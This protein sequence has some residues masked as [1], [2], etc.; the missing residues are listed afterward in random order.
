MRA[1]VYTAGTSS[2]SSVRQIRLIN[3]Y[4]GSRSESKRTIVPNTVCICQHTPV[5]QNLANDQL[6]PKIFKGSK[7]FLR[8]QFSKLS[9]PGIR[10]VQ[11]TDPQYVCRQGTYRTRPVYTPYRTRPVYTPRYGRLRP[12][13][14]QMLCYT[15]AID[16]IDL[17][18][19]TSSSTHLRTPRG[20]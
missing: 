9:C 11:H 5:M 7:Y 15:H 17:R 4:I 12:A 1:D 3:F 10:N 18:R 6:T 16:T 8:H 20:A 13:F 14:V 19:G 2:V